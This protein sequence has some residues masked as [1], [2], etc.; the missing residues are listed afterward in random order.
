MKKSIKG[1]VRWSVSNS[2]SRDISLRMVYIPVTLLQRR[3]I[4]IFE[5]NNVKNCD[6]SHLSRSDGA[7]ICYGLLD[8]VKSNWMVRPF[9]SSCDTVVIFTG[10]GK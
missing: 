4:S 10:F 3:I 6:M 7:I 8:S 1:E 2:I 9:D 5:R